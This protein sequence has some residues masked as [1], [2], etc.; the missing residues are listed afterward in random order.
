MRANVI[1][2][3]EAIAR[4]REYAKANGRK[5]QE[6]SDIKLQ[7]RQTAGSQENQITKRPVYS[8]TIGTSRPMPVV[9]IDAIDGT[10]LEWRTLPR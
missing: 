1:S 4:V 3:A 9:D 5:F 10:V 2:E 8:M 7:H 6:P